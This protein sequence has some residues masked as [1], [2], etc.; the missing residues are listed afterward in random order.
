MFRLAPKDVSAVL[1]SQNLSTKSQK[2][3]SLT[4]MLAEEVPAHIMARAVQIK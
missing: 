2:E 1:E 3:P 4:V